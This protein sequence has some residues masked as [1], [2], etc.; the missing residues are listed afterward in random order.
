MDC[1][2]AID[3]ETYAPPPPPPPQFLEL[4]ENL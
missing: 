1:I 4:E 2:G 3:F